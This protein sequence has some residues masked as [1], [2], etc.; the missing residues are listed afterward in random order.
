MEFPT[1]NYGEKADY[2]NVERSEWVL[3]NKADHKAQASN[4]RDARTRTEQKEIE[5]EH[6]VKYSMLNE[7]P[8]FNPPL[9][10]VIDPMHNLLLGTSKHMMSVWKTLNILNE[11]DFAAIQEKV[12]SLTCPTDMGRIPLK[13]ASVAVTGHRRDSY[14]LVST[15]IEYPSCCWPA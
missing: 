11:N 12:N 14:I 8:Y 10:C 4:H 15:S 7:L 13:I 5:R 1:D 9:M 3:R 2:T 6:G